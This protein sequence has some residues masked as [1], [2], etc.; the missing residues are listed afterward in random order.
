LLSFVSQLC[1]AVKLLDASPSVFPQIVQIES[2]EN[3]DADN[4]YVAFGKGE[5]RDQGN[6]VEKEYY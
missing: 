6:N 1:F 2:L 3:P 4:V 5:F